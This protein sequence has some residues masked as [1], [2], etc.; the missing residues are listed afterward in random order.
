MSG[1][2]FWS[3]KFLIFYFWIWDEFFGVSDVVGLILSVYVMFK[4][5]GFDILDGG[6]WG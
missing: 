6:L 5:G 4:C 3:L 1:F 2:G